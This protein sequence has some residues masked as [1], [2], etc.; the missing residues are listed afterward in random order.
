MEL[1]IMKTDPLLIPYD[2]QLQERHE[3][4]LATRNSLLKPGE[5]LSD[6]AN[7]HLFFGFHRTENGWYYREWA[8]GADAV[9]LTGD[10]NNWNRS[11]CPLTRKNN[12]IFEI[13]LQGKDALKDR[14]RVCAVV[15]RNGNAMD[16]IPSYAKYVV[17]DPMTASWNGVIYAPESSVQ[18]TDQAF[19]P[20]RFLHIYECHIGMAQEKPAIGTY[21]EFRVNILPRIRSLGYNAIQIMAIM[22]H[23]YYASFGYQVTNFFAPSSKF[24]TPN[25]LKELI[26]AA[27]GMGIAVL[28]DVVHSHAAPNSREGLNL[29]DGTEYQYFHRG[30][31]GNHSAWGTKCFDYGKH[32]VI[33]FLLS[34]LKYWATEFHFDGFR[35]DGVTSML[36]HDHGLGI[37]FGDYKKY[38]SDNVNLEA[39]TYLQ[40]ANELIHSLN[41]NAITIAEDTSAMPGLCR[42]IEEGGIGFD[43]RLAM[44]IPD[45]W[46]RLLKEQRD[47]DWDMWRIWL[48]LSGRRPKEKVIGY[49][50]SHDQALVGDKT[51]MFR[52]CDQE[53]YWGMEKGNENL[54]ID[55]GMALHKM[56]RLITMSL[57]GE[58]YLTFMGNEFGHPEW[59]DFP[60]AGNDWSYHYCRRQWSLPD[61]PTLRYEYLLNFDK[62]MLGLAHSKQ[63]FGMIPKNLLISN[64]DKV[65]IYKMGNLI[66]AFNFHPSHSYNSY[67]IPVDRV[68]KYMVALSTDD[69]CFGG[70]GRIAKDV[71]Y[72]AEAGD[73]RQP[74]F[75][76][77]LPSRTAVVLMR[78]RIRSF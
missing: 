18:W 68:C 44:G 38:F 62:A 26:N 75:L 2:R 6:F 60:R 50:E 69:R 61:N 9:Y 54:V 3:R 13:F 27:H 17:Q 56:I 23:P 74:G 64:S 24:G 46:I 73:N 77:Y 40:L 11:S 51:L 20:K 72:Q 19:K 37:A 30:M 25:Q 10:F 33:H 71:V 58:G 14:Q 76:L 63:I 36:Y 29:F 45:M 52:L 22:E 34:N 28:L 4:Y 67:Y 41:P 53:M 16:R 70:Q 65:I 42:P 32:E 8:P 15:V 55:R 49:V 5:S 1:A 78:E 12:G 43:Y 47:E 31:K 59:I 35:F 21:D 66:F 39:I 48:E 57:G 7:G